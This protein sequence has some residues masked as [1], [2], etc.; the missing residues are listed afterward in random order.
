MSFK[1][2]LTKKCLKKQP[3]SKAFVLDSNTTNLSDVAYT[4]SST[5][6]GLNCSNYKFMVMRPSMLDYC[7]V[8][9]EKVHFDQRLFQKEYRKALRWLSHEEGEYLQQWSARRFETESRS[10][11]YNE[12]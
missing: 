9:L 8:I 12:R 7:K 11:A 10:F 6:Y 1:Y 2:E 5:A 4:D 3:Y